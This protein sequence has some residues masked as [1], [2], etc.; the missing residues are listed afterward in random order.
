V[1]SPVRNLLTAPNVYYVGLYIDIYRSTCL[2]KQCS[3]KLISKFRV[4]LLAIKGT[5]HGWWWIPTFLRNVLPPS[6]GQLNNVMIYKDTGCR[7]F[8]CFNI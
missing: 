3:G 4:L 8:L 5:V 6:A 1:N 2:L 7:M